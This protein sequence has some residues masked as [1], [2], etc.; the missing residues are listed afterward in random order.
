M[1]REI[2]SWDG[3]TSGYVLNVFGGPT[4]RVGN[5]VHPHNCPHMRQMT[6]PPRKV[7]GDTV[8]ELEAWVNARGGELDPKTPKCR[9]V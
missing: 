1:A 3:V 5:T 6:L 2:T 8:E 7:W 9:Y 4:G